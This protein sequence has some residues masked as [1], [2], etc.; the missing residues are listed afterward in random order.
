MTGF[1][2]TKLALATAG[3]LFTATAT[4]A[5]G[6]E[7]SYP[8]AEP[9]FASNLLGLA[10]AEVSN[11]QVLSIDTVITDLVIGRTTGFGIRMTLTGAEFAA[12]ATATIGTGIDEDTDFDGLVGQAWS[13]ASETIAGNV[14]TITI[15]PGAVPAGLPVGEIMNF[16]VNALDV[17][18]VNGSLGMG[19]TVTAAIELFDPVTATVL[20]ENSATLYTAQEG[21]LV[22]IAGGDT[23]SR[24]DVGGAVNSSKTDHSPDGTINHPT[25][26]DIFHAG[27]VTAGLNPD[28]TSAAGTTYVDYNA[29]DAFNYDADGDDTLTVTLTG[30]DFGSFTS[31]WLEQ[32]AGILVADACTA[33]SAGVGVAD[34]NTAGV[35]TPLDAAGEVLTADIDFATT[36]ESFYVCLETNGTDIIDDQGLDV[37]AS[38]DLDPAPEYAAGALV[39]PADTA[40]A[41][42]PLQYN[43]DV[44]EVH[45]FNDNQ[46]VGQESRIRVSNKGNTAGLVRIVG[47][48]DAGVSSAEAVITLGA[49]ESIQL[50]SS[51]LINGTGAVTGAMGL[52]TQGKWRLTVTAEYDGLEVTNFVR[53][54]ESGILTNFT[55]SKE[56][57]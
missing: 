7:V 43:G 29:A 56:A 1:N 30:T 27:T 36:G 9:A 23:V 12:G 52:P 42:T 41:I 18:A 4:A 49:E 8:A 31:V 3:V 40:G 53:N 46:N 6:L 54:I 48:D 50:R 13:I 28:G 19:G 34:V 47:I 33:G 20:L 38:I 51:D 2:K 32:T 39:D 55:P 37:S 22:T 15:E 26:V 14:A 21:T 44:I 57:N 11:T 25:P 24:V 10:T 45:F 35:G 17:T 16:A 5:P